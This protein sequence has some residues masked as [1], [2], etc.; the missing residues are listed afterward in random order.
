[1]KDR[2]SMRYTKRL[3]SLIATKGEWQ[4]VKVCLETLNI[5]YYEW[6]VP[7]TCLTENEVTSCSETDE[8]EKQ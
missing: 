3:V 6:H 1:M 5:K 8:S 2:R 4:K 7:K